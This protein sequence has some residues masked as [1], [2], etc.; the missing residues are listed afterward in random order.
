MS[1]RVHFELRSQA[2]V[3]GTPEICARKEEAGDE[4]PLV[5]VSMIL[6]WK[7]Q[8]WRLDLHVESLI[9]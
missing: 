9:G 7:L 2:A 4:T 8:E 6:K 1:S 3:N 5:Q